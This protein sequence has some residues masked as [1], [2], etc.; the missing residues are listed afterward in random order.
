MDGVKPCKLKLTVYRSH[1]GSQ[2]LDQCQ[3]LDHSSLILTI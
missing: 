3:I 2:V 1:E